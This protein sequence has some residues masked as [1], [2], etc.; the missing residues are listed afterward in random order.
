MLIGLKLALDSSIRCLKFIGDYDLI[1]SQVNL[2]FGTKNER[3][4]R[5]KDSVQDTIKIFDEFLIE[6]IPR[7]QNYVNDALVVSAS[8]LQP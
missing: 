3:L 1:V 6:A 8:T 7:E 4:R 2:K 5:Y